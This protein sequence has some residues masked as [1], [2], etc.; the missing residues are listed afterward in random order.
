MSEQAPDPQRQRQAQKY[1]R[2]M[3]RL[4]FLELALG[5]VF[6]LTILFSGLSTGLRSLLDLPQSARVALY[7]LIVML[8]YTIVSAPLNIY[9]SFVIPHRYGLSCQSWGAWLADEAKEIMLGSALGTCLV[10]VIYIFLQAFPQMWWLLAFAFVSLVVIIMTKLA[11]VVIL[12]L[13][14]K[15]EP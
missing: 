9:R 15:L 6:L 12:P 13:F 14:F 3:R 10:L 4:F 2:L 11:P 5:G 1:A 8:C 7:F